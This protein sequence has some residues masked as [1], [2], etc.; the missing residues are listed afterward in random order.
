MSSFKFRVQNLAFGWCRVVMYINDKMISY[1]ASYLGQNPLAT[2]IDACADLMDEDGDYYIEWQQEPGTLKID[3]NLDENKMLHFDIINHNGNDIEP[4]WH[5]VVPFADVVLAIQSEGFRVLNA[6]GLCGYRKSWQNDVDFPLTNLL[7]IT[8]DC[9]NFWNG[10]SCTSNLQE[11]ISC[12]SEHI[13]ELV[14]KKETHYD[15]CTIFYESWQIQCCGDPFSVGDRIEWTCH[16]PW[17]YKNAH[18]F[19]LDFEEDHHG[20]STH[21]ITGTVSRIIVERGEFPKGKRVENITP[22]H[23]EITKADG[24]ESNYPDDKDT[25]RTFWGYIVMLNDVIVKPIRE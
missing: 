21:T 15:E 19:P 14:I 6:F 2:L 13:S 12:L 9:K 24:W 3:M 23:E 18:G 20:S 5:E 16:M 17:E 7:R 8:G 11:E 4:E 10:D 25:E 22:I 1:N